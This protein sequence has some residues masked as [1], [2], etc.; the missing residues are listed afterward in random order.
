MNQ[1][2]ASPSLSQSDLTRLA[3]SQQP[4]AFMDKAGFGPSSDRR[5]DGLLPP[6]ELDEP[7]HPRVLTNGPAPSGTTHATARF[8]AVSAR[9]V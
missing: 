7:Q 5:A 2:N 4:P 8:R 1:G 6:V 9:T 3:V